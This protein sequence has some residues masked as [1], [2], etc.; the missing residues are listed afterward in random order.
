M[1][2][3]TLPSLLA[4]VILIVMRRLCGVDPGVPQLLDTSGF[5]SLIARFVT[6]LQ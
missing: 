2:N 1:K 6:E 3:Q 5:S 4:N